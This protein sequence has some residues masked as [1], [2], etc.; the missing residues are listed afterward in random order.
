[1]SYFYVKNSLGTRT[2]GG[3]L[4]LQTGSF[5]TLGAA[6]VYATIEA[7][8]AD[9][10]TAGDHIM[11]SDLHDY[12]AVATSIIYNGPTTG[13]VAIISVD[14]ANCDQY[15]AGAQERTTSGSAADIDLSGLIGAW[16]MSFAPIDDFRTINPGTQFRGHQCKFGPLQAS[17]GIRALADGQKI[18]LFDCSIEAGHAAAQLFISEYAGVF[19]M[20]GGVFWRIS[21]GINNLSTGNFGGG[22]GTFELFG[23][24]LTDVDNYLFFNTG[25]DF[26]PDDK[27]SITMDMCK[28]NAAVDSGGLYF[29]QD[30]SKP[31]NEISITRC[32][33]SSADAEHRYYRKDFGGEI[34]DDTTIYRDASTAFEDSGQKVSLKVVTGANNSLFEPLTFDF[35]TV[36]AALSSAATD[37]LRIY[38]LCADALTDNDIWAQAMY[39]DGTTKN[40]GTVATSNGNT[41]VG[42]FVVDPLSAGSPLAT[43]TEAWTGRTAENRYHV[44]IDT[45]ADPGVDC[46]PLIR[47]YIAKASTTMYLDTDVDVVS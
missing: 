22:G 17:D 16:G 44:D 35:P 9:G 32:S 38:I 15:K 10:A 24:D 26:T 11:C 39:P 3:G 1:M 33:S 47:L 28:L 23:V 36:F 42:S 40:L 5:E 27:I 18:E 43:N 46:V 14:D 7:A 4:T 20:F 25:E 6:S 30:F 41:V 13:F 19:R 8:L 45:S 2:T 21:N 29:N 37:T 34:A 12:D 31:L